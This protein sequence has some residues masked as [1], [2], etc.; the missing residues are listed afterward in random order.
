MFQK[1]NHLALLQSDFLK[2]AFRSQV[3]RGQCLLHRW[4]IQPRFRINLEPPE[5]LRQHFAPHPAGTSGVLLG[6]SVLD[7]NLALRRNRVLQ[8]L[9]CRAYIRIG[10][11][12]Q[13]LSVAQL[14]VSRHTS[15]GLAWAATGGVEQRP[16]A[17]V[18]EVGVDA[19]GEIE[20]GRTLGQRKHLSLRAEHL[21]LLVLHRAQYI[22]H[23]QIRL[24]RHLIQLIQIGLVV[25]R[26][27]RGRSGPMRHDAVT[28]ALVH[29]VRDDFHR[30]SLSLKQECRPQ[31]LIAVPAWIGDVIPHLPGNRTQGHVQVPQRLIAVKGLRYCDLESFQHMIHW[32]VAENV[33]RRL[34]KERFDGQQ[35]FLE[36]PHNHPQTLPHRLNGP[37]AFLLEVF[38]RVNRCGVAHR[39]ENL[40]AQLRMLAADL[41]QPQTLGHGHIHPHSF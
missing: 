32:S 12:A 27:F 26:Q 9:S 15:S 41:P 30:D 16:D 10:E 4:G 21:H 28:V 37:A 19:V 17:M 40:K 2:K 34:G 11:D 29:L 22:V 38:Q 20:H 7:L 8:P 31:S 3:F 1:R 39:V 25:I 13:A 24:T 36:R 6:D 5:F 23:A 35:F 18:A 14:T 33:I